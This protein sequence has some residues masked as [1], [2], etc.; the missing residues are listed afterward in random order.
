[1][2]SSQPIDGRPAAAKETDPAMLDRCPVCGCEDVDT[3]NEVYDDRYAFAGRFALARCLGCGA[4]FLRD[5][6]PAER[7]SE[8]YGRYYPRRETAA[9]RR[10]AIATAAG[11][12]IDGVNRSPE[13]AF[14]LESG[15]VLD[16]GCGTGGS[17]AVVR[18]RGGTWIGLELDARK[19]D[20]MRRAGL[21]AHAIPLEEFSQSHAGEFDGVLA[22]Q[23]LEHLGSPGE[24][25]E[26]CRRLLRRG[27]R[28]ALSTPNFASRHRARLGER[29]I[30]I[31]APYH[32][33]LYTR[34][35]IEIACG[36]HGFGIV[37]YRE[38]TPATWS[39]HQRRYE[40]PR[41]GARGSWYER[42][43]HLPAVALAG[44]VTRLGDL[45]HGG[46]DCIVTVVEKL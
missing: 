46:G 42:R 7:M 26:P 45:V 12:L 16:V 19:V 14:E 22:S 21:E 25:L 3:L 31:H 30:N 11:A 39:V 1:V 18:F 38:V 2:L 28:L 41:E 13:L 34:R 35:A 33:V 20:A 15:R 43:V 37:R 23:L 17:E 32:Q 24:L 29:W 6:L 9:R 40:A 44:V 5:P 36:N 4:G 27:G 8:L 10:G